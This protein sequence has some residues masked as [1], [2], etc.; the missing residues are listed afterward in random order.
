MVSP[1][2]TGRAAP[3]VLVFAVARARLGVF[4]QGDWRVLSADGRRAGT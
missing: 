2:L 3:A 1:T 4:V